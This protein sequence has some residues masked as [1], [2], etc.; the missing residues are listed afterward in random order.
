[1]GTLAVLSEVVANQIAAGEVV[2]RP[3]NVVKELL[4]NSLDA[5]ASRICVRFRDGGKTFISVEDDGKGMAAREA[6]LCF[7]R[8]ATSKIG[9]IEDLR[10][11]QTYGFRGEALPSIAS[12]SRV[13]L[14]TRPLGEAIGIRVKINGGRMEESGPCGCPVGTH[15]CVEQ[16]FYNVPARRKFLKSDSTETENIVRWVRLYA[17]AHPALHFELESDH[18]KMLCLPS[19]S[20]VFT[21]VGE[22]YPRRSPP[23]WVAF[24]EEVRGV[25]LEGVLLPP[26]FGESSGGIRIFVNRR[27]IL[28]SFLV[29]VIREAYRGFLPAGLSPSVFLFLELD[30]EQVDVNVHPAKREVR[31]RDEREIQNVVSVTVRN[32]LRRLSGPSSMGLSDPVVEYR[33][34]PFS[35]VLRTD[36]LKPSEVRTAGVLAEG[37]PLQAWRFLAS[38]RNDYLLFDSGK[39]LILLNAKAT[40]RRIVYEEVRER[41]GK[42]GLPSQG[43]LAPY[44]FECDLAKVEG[45]LAHLDFFNACCGVSLRHFGR[46][47]FSLESLP[48]WIQ[49]GD[50]PS[51]MGELLQLI[52]RGGVL[53]ATDGVSESMARL[54]ASRAQRAPSCWDESAACGLLKNLF[55][56]HNMAVS[57]EGTPLWWEILATEIEKHVK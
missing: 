9:S 46:C 28:S 44:I 45:V 40:L 17:V 43:L 20:S 15:L 24:G 31:F 3:A 30:P 41:M 51:F 48:T 4:E 32:F 7:Q 53:E 29:G 11:V 16:L 13:L 5:D 54:I 56:C 8:Y 22:L 35:T 42:E 47:A 57:P 26:G 27:P 1:M 21:R 33:T 14:Q 34:S 38:W 25:H 23:D 2:E 52:D 50:E 37:H 49:P 6:T 55:R 12:V 10:R 36:L 39:G 18:G 19:C